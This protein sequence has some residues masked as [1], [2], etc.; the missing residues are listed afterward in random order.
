MRNNPGK[1]DILALSCG[2]SVHKF[3]EQILEFKPKFATM[4]DEILLALVKTKTSHIGVKYISGKNCYDVLLNEIDNFDCLVG[5]IPGIAGMIPTLTVMEKCKTLAIANKESVVCA[6]KFFQEKARKLGVKITPIDSEHDSLARIMRGILPSD[7][8]K[9]TLTASGGAFFGY[10][11]EQLESVKLCDAIKH[12]NWKMGAKVTIDC[13][14]MVNKALELMEAVA[15]FNL[16]YKQVDAIIHR[17]S[18][19]HA[20]LEENDGSVSA[21]LAPPDMRLHILHAISCEDFTPI[22]PVKSLSLVEIGRLDFAPIPHDIYKS[23]YLGLY[24]LKNGQAMQII[25]N[26]ANEFAV[27]KFVNEEAKFTDI[28]MLIDAALS[29]NFPVNISTIEDISSLDVMVRKFCSEVK[30]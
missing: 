8:K 16:S 15:L 29:T 24:A 27:Q 3:I 28:P 13:A 25:F 18:I 5:A 21:F 26:S 11:P 12:P 22:F 19:V 6:W 1:F 14:T 9:I 23:F 30:L 4:E 17:Q 20:M 10:S 7:I 2:K